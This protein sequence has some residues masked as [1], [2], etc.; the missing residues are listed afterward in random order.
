MVIVFSLLNGHFKKMKKVR[1]EGWVFKSL[2]NLVSICYVCMPYQELTIILYSLI[3]YI[4][5][6]KM[7]CQHCV[8]NIIPNQNIS[9]YPLTL[10]VL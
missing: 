7:A 10:F 8:H 9:G 2:R 5:C 3:L 4:V 6:D 1:D